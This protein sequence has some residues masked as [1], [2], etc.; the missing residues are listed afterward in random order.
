MISHDGL[1]Q[2]LM[3]TFRQM[4][5]RRFPGSEAP[6]EDPFRSP[7]AEL[8]N[9]GINADQPGNDLDESPSETFHPLPPPITAHSQG[10]HRLLHSQHENSLL[11]RS[12][13][14]RNGHPQLSLPNAS[15]KIPSPSET[16]RTQSH[17]QRILNEREWSW[18]CHVL[19]P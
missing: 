6:H 9:R 1:V 13:R 14:M 10:P 11:C 3:T 15:M 8:L 2:M 4:A 16:N 7:S 12:P 19:G 18:M 17:R 5:K